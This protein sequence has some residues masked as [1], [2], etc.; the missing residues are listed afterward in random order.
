MKKINIQLILISFILTLISCNQEDILDKYDCKVINIEAYEKGSIETYKTRIYI[1]IP[2]EITKDEITEIAEYL[3]IE[4]NQN[5][6]LYISYLLPKMG[7][8]LLGWANASYNP[9]LEIKIN[10]IKNVVAE[11][12]KN[13]KVP[14]ESSEV[15]GKWYDDSPHTKSS[16]LI[17]KI[18]EKYK[19][20]SLLDDG[21]YDTNRDLEYSNENGKDKFTYDNDDGEYLMIESDG[22]LG[23]YDNNGLIVI[24][25]KIN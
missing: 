23:I 3:R 1:R 20:K 16:H 2:K 21:K 8:S 7:P 6:L 19:M 25:T 12:L 10:G 24:S 22:S 18:G 17:Y 5:K 14:K 15:I 9:N 11:T 13:I 4:Y